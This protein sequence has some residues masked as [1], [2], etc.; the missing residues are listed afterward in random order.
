MKSM[1]T[2]FDF[3]S[4]CIQV[5]NCIQGKNCI[6]LT[7]SSLLRFPSFFFSWS[8]TACYLALFS[9]S[10]KNKKSISGE[11]CSESVLAIN[12]EVLLVF[13]EEKDIQL[14]LNCSNMGLL[15][16]LL[17]IEGD[18]YLP[19]TPLPRWLLNNLDLW[20]NQLLQ[21]Q[22]QSTHG[23]KRFGSTSGKS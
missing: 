17:T 8:V 3:V 10:I 15:T 12:D 22:I 16:E 13:R 4:Y 9:I 21:E 19:A 20:N 5:K 11:F 1:T 18:L 23:L 6:Q 14:M 7:N 2:P